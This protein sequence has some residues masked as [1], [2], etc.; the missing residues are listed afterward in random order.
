M[1]IGLP[2]E[3][4]EFL[5]DGFGLPKPVIMATLLATAASMTACNVVSSSALLCRT[6]L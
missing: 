3:E 6:C 2:D 4:V 5:L 1:L